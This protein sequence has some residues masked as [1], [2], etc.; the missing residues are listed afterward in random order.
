MQN[1][2]IIFI[3]LMALAIG[4]GSLVFAVVLYLP[5]LD[6]IQQQNEPAEHSPAF[7]ALE[8]L[9]PT[10]FVSLLLLIASGIYY[11]MENYTRQVDL[12]S[13]YY[14]LFGVKILFVILSFFLSVYQTFNLRPRIANLDLRPENREQVP[15]TL[16]KMRG[17]SFIILASMVLAALIGTWLSRY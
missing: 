15:A 13:E 3:H 8:I 10:V 17:L 9:S 12:T 16:K 11:L 2:V 1:T 14:N 5:V 4:I 6:K 7:Q